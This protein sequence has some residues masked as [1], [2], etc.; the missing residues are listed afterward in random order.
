LRTFG[1]AVLASTA[2][3]VAGCGGSTPAPVKTVDAAETGT[4]S[5]T[6]PKDLPALC[7]QL[8]YAAFNDPLGSPNADA[9]S[10]VT[11]DGQSV[12]GVRCSQ[13]FTGA[14]LYTGIVTTTIAFLP[15]VASAQGV[16]KLDRPKDDLESGSLVDVHGA[17]TEAFQYISTERTDGKVLNVVVRRSN[18][19]VTVKAVVSSTTSSITDASVA[20]LFTRIAGYADKELTA[21]KVTASP[22]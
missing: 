8:D 13:V 16:F 21:L 18:A 2:L 17:G 11:G 15:D 1:I 19:M 22:S 12:K 3:G 9:K 14:P 10:E 7:R 20:A 6:A 4:G 5:Y